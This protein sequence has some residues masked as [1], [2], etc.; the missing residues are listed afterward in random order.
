MVAYVP[1]QK[2]PVI[3][4]PGKPV[5]PHPPAMLAFML[6]R[7]DQGPVSF[8]DQKK[9]LAYATPKVYDELVGHPEHPDGAR[10]SQR[11]KAWVN[12]PIQTPAN[13]ADAHWLLHMV[14]HLPPP[15]MQRLLLQSGMT[16]QSVF[17]KALERQEAGT[18]G[19]LQAEAMLRVCSPWL[20]EASPQAQKGL[21]TF[22]I[23]CLDPK[24]P[25]PQLF[26]QALLVQAD[27]AADLP[28]LTID[29]QRFP[30]LALPDGCNLIDAVVAIAPHASD[31]LDALRS[32]HDTAAM[33]RA[34]C[35]AFDR[36]LAS[37]QALPVESWSH[38]AARGWLDDDRVRQ[39][40]Q[41]PCLAEG[42]DR[43]LPFP[44]A[45]GLA[46]GNDSRPLHVPRSLDAL[47]RV[48][49]LGVDVEGQGTWSGPK[50]VQ[51]TGTLLHAAIEN[52]RPDLAEQ[53]LRHAQQ[54]NAPVALAA[55]GGSVARIVPA[56]QWAKDLNQPWMADAVEAAVKTRLAMDA[57]DTSV[58][59]PKLVRVA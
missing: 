58:A 25:S 34:C 44:I 46:H 39:L 43:P 4:V 54:P 42:Q 9:W 50:G 41:A 24:N 14:H 38:L 47:R 1:L 2:L 5:A 32:F 20:R 18:L 55:L 49:D 12:A 52:V 56:T 3:R 36:A 10:L 21:S 59:K 33:Q 22:L 45:L 19:P 17:T 16:A 31:T 26:G 27:M 29:R 8:N 6:D 35:A 40:A 51:R 28:T 37:Q 11:M 13:D 7:H 30:S 53:Y 48:Q 57:I 15:T 23:A